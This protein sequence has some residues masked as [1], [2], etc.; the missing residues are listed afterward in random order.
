MHAIAI[1]IIPIHNVRHLRLDPIDVTGQVGRAFD[2][3]VS[4]DVGII[5][6]P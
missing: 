2:I 5:P 4:T 1:Q 3:D 6:P